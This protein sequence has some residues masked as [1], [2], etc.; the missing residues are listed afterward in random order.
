[1]LNGI[2]P[3]LREIFLRELEVLINRFNKI[4]E[5]NTQ[6]IKEAMELVERLELTGTKFQQLETLLE[7]AAL[8]NQYGIDCVE[9]Y[10]WCQETISNVID[11]QEV[12]NYLQ[13]MEDDK[14]VAIDD[15]VIYP[16]G[17][18]LTEFVKDKLQ[19]IV[20]ES[21]HLDRLLSKDMLIEMW[22]QGTTK[23]ELE[24]ELMDLDKE[25]LLDT[26]EQVAYTS[27]QGIQYMYMQVEL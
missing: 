16:K 1:M 13:Q 5:E 2:L 21:Y 19:E 24:D 3:E 12:Q 27:K 7:V 25:D 11:I 9:L 22:F 8:I 10:L 15:T 18:D 17:A 4:G 26:I 6:G 14:Y 23:E 20:S